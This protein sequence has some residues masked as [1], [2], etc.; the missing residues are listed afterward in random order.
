MRRSFQPRDP[1]AVKEL[2]MA[3][4]FPAK[5]LVRNMAEKPSKRRRRPPPL[6]GTEK[7]NP[8]AEKYRGTNGG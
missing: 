5:G 7:R 4:T 1:E 2:E 3:E 8:L 6:P